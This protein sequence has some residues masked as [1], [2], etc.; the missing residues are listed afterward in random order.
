MIPPIRT[1]RVVNSRS[2]LAAGY[3]LLLLWSLRLADEYAPLVVVELACVLQQNL[4]PLP[5]TMQAHLHG[6]QRKAQ[7]HGNLRCCEPVHIVQ[8]EYGTTDHHVTRYAQ[9]TRR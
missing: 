4:H 8:Y 7:H 5:G 3:G 1:A 6:R 9:L 2:R